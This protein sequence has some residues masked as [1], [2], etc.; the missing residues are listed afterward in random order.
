M[1]NNAPDAPEVYSPANGSTGKSTTIVLSW[2]GN[3][4]DGDVLTYNV[5]FGTSP[6][7][8]QIVSSGKK[9]D[10]LEIRNLAHNT[11]Y[12]WKIIAKDNKGASTESLV[13]SFKTGDLPNLAPSAPSNPNPASNLTILQPTVLAIS[14][15][16]DDPNG[17]PLTYDVYFGTSPS[18]DLFFIVSV[19]Q[20]EKSYTPSGLTTNTTYY[21]KI[22][23]KDDKGASTIGQLWQ[24]ITVPPPNN[25]PLAPFNPSPA[26]NL[27][28]LQTTTVSLT[29]SCNDPDGDA[30][31]YD[32]YFGTNSSPNIM[33]SSNQTEKSYSPSALTRNTNYYWKIVAKDGKGGMTIGSVWN[34]KTNQSY[35][36]T[37]D[38][39]LY[40][41][42][43][44]GNLVWT[45]ENLQTTKYIDETLIAKITDNST[46]STSTGGAYCVY[47]NN[48]TNVATYG[49]LYNWHAVNTGK[50]APAGWRVPTDAD[51]TKLETEVGGSANAGT[52]LKATSGWKNNGN[53]TDFYGFSA[54]PGGA[55][56]FDGVF[57]ILGDYGVWWSSTPFGTNSAWYR[58]IGSGFVNV[59]RFDYNKRNGFSVRLVRDVQE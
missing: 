7:T 24:F 42:V 31:T 58:M 56:E 35:D 54:L 41:T 39:H 5:Y 13:W 32:V 50:L 2:T 11:T 1:T 57:G 8:I 59:V 12:Y 19:N 18:P 28:T 20:T 21:W 17:D 53:G 52:K 16:C 48:E 25:P 30:L 22:V 40:K 26:S 27:S 47:D 45:V 10:Y 3:D 33:V 44:I 9:E 38:G 4:P 15:S 49:Y 14:W 23:A 43:V 55:R 51:W 6:A 34:F 29:W 36:F 37:F 46:W